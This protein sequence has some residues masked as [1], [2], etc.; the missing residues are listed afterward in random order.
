MKGKTH[1]A[2]GDVLVKIEHPSHRNSDAS[3]MMT[4]TNESG[5]FGIGPF[6]KA[7][8]TVHL[9]KEDYTFTRLASESASQH[10]FK[11]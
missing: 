8:Y 9:E 3:S 2:I 10:E 7:D 5:E 6:E 11:A 4:R 1:P